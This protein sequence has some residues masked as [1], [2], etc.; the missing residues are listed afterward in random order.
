MKG[1]KV[2][3]KG[4]FIESMEQLSAV[5][6]DCIDEEEGKICLR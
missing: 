3:H 1:I 6:F 5:K 4:F 2:L